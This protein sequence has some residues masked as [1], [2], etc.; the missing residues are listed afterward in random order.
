MPNL[1][2]SL[3]LALSATVPRA[4][5]AQLPHEP[6]APAAR[7]SVS[8]PG[9]FAVLRDCDLPSAISQIAEGSLISVSS[10]YWVAG[11]ASKTIAWS[12]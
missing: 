12:Q 6:D 1:S 9:A 2:A 8:L 5:K 4:A 10:A 11:S 7:S 3:A